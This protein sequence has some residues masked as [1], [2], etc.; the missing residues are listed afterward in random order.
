MRSVVNAHIPY[1]TPGL[2][3]TLPESAHLQLLEPHCAGCCA[4]KLHCWG[5]QNAPIA[6]L[7]GELLVGESSRL[8][9]W[10]TRGERPLWAA[11]RSWLAYM[12]LE[13]LVV[14]RV[15]PA[16]AASVATGAP[17]PR[18]TAPER[19]AAAELALMF[20]VARTRAC[21]YCTRL[22]EL[23][24]MQPCCAPRE[25]TFCCESSSLSVS[26][27]GTGMSGGGGCFWHSSEMKARSSAHAVVA[28]ARSHVARHSSAARW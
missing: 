15:R 19:A 13:V 27:A 18:V 6:S 1:T 3:S 10:R 24:C 14:R 8:L 22:D 20:C 16:A 21:V 2:Q 28:R 4:H 7:T 26:S 23:M 9:R 12:W 11:A 17:A 25:M 5:S